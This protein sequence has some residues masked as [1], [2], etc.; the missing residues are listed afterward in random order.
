M[1]VTKVGCTLP[2]LVF[3]VH[4]NSIDKSSFTAVFMKRGKCY[5]IQFFDDSTV[6]KES[7]ALISHILFDHFSKFS[8]T[9]SYFWSTP[10]SDKS[11]L[12]L[13]IL[14][15]GCDGLGSPEPVIIGHLISTGPFEFGIRVRSIN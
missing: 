10:P 6:R 13:S 5:K 4:R 3:T 12:K 8:I 14:K 7:T 15:R 9:S 11:V 2:K 1:Y